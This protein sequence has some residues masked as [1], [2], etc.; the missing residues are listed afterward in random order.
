M[1]GGFAVHGAHVYITM[2]ELNTVAAADADL[3]GGHGFLRR[4]R[5]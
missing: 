4:Y 5:R 3:G 1:V 2:R